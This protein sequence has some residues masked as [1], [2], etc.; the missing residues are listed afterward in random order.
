MFIEPLLCAVRW[1]ST[2]ERHTPQ[3]CSGPVSWV[4]WAPGPSPSHLSTPCGSLFSLC[5]STP[6]REPCHSNRSSPR[7][8]CCLFIWVANSLKAETTFRPPWGPPW[9]VLTTQSANP[10]QLSG[11]REGGGVWAQQSGQPPPQRAPGSLP[12]PHLC[13]EVTPQGTCNLHHNPP[14]QCPSEYPAAKGPENATR[15]G[16]APDRT[17]APSLRPPGSSPPPQ[18]SKVTP[19]KAHRGSS[20]SFSQSPNTQPR[21]TRSKMQPGAKH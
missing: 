21:N 8:C 5:T 19:A 17:A 1:V 20:H 3:S 4:L 2:G 7:G 14:P 10:S 13:R 15:R 11:C 18:G 12:H 16:P 9:K 6:D